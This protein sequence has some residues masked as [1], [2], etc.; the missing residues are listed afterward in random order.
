MFKAQCGWLEKEEGC[1]RQ[2][3]QKPSQDARMSRVQVIHTDEIEEKEEDG[4]RKA[5][6]GLKG[7]LSL[8]QK[9]Q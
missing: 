3:Q 5:G 9:G 4:S 7:L 2:Q 1:I 6:G 8:R